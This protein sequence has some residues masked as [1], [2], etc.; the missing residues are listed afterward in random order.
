MPTTMSA[1][2][3]ESV[4]GATQRPAVSVL[5]EGLKGVRDPRVER[6]KLHPLINILF[7]TLAGVVAGA[8]D[9]VSIAE[10][11]AIKK[12]WLAAFLDLSNGIPSHDTFGRVFRLLDPNELQR[13]L[14]GWVQSVV[15]LNK[16][17]VV[18]IDGKQLCGSQDAPSGRAAIHM[19]SAWAC[20]NHLVLGQVKADE[21]S[22]ESKAIPHLLELL[23]VLDLKGCTVTVD[24][25]GTYADVVSAINA[26]G[27][28]WVL[29]LK[30]NQPLLHQAVE[31]Y[32]TGI[33]EQPPAP[34]LKTPQ[35]AY[36]RTFDD[37]HGRSETREYWLTE[38]QG[39]M[40]WLFAVTDKEPWPG[41]HSIGMVRRQRKV[42]VAAGG[43]KQVSK[44]TVEVTYY[45]TSLPAASQ[46]DVQRFAQAARSH[47]CIENQ[48]H[49]VL[50]V[51]FNQDN[52]RSRKDNSAHNLAIVHHLA[53]NLLK[54]ETSRRIGI[55]NRRLR[56]GWD[57]DYI[58]RVIFTRR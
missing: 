52:N 48:L 22:N 25:A 9:W 38:D 46:K 21:K 56:A 32:F 34:T 26:K 43:A 11:G 58:S 35:P 53:L 20:E 40:D 4:D 30:E 16:G 39:D 1:R 17:E 55:K 3:G 14:V 8:D 50:D 27:A 42:M 29:P 5:L 54:Q 13:C 47:W 33:L 2:E 41:V 15:S 31:E 51:A 36:V 24:G 18:A 57:N 37:A 45:L 49:W 23:S 44:E 6:T 10:Y 12:E 28:N 19:V 7:I